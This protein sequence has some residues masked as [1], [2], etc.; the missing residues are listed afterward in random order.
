MEI[1]NYISINQ[2]STVYNISIDLV[3]V[4][5]EEGLVQL[6]NIK[7]VQYLHHDNLSLFEKILRIHNELKVNIE[8]IDVVLNL[9]DKI[10]G[11]QDELTTT[12]NKLFLYEGSK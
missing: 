12:Q 11:L 3:I 4:L 5:E 8:G 1:I 7:Q 2:L 6:E 10:N 9:L